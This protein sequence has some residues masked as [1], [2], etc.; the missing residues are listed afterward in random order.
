[1]SLS[2]W[3]HCCDESVS[4]SLKTYFGSKCELTGTNGCSTASCSTGATCFPLDGSGNYNCRCATGTH[5]SRCE[6]ISNT[7]EV[8]STLINR[9]MQLCLTN[10]CAKKRNNGVCNIE[11]NFFGCD[12]DGSDCSA[13]LMPYRDC[14]EAALCSSLS[15]DGKCDTRCNTE[16]CLW[17]GGDCV[18]KPGQCK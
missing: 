18:Q 10:E 11:C 3:C 12:Y 15:G 14:K 4:F 6:Q 13:G 5:G 17:D 8:V 1:M 16:V 2:Q 7:S 9:D